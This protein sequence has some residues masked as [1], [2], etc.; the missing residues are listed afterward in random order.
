MIP[1]RELA[2]RY[3]T[4]QFADAYERPSHTLD[5]VQQDNSGIYIIT[6]PDWN[7]QKVPQG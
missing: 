3:Y 7:G 4:L 5:Y 1:P 2:N 6:G